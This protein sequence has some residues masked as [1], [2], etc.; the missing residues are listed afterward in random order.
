[1]LLYLKQIL[2]GI[3]KALEDQELEY[4]K[5]YTAIKIPRFKYYK[6]EEQKSTLEN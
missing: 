3:N 4:K 2:I 6:V 5:E 1:M